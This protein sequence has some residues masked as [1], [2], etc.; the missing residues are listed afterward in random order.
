MGG[1]EEVQTTISPEVGR[2]IPEYSEYSRVF[3]V[4]TI[5]YLKCPIFNN[6]LTFKERG[7]CDSSTGK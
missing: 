2:S 6:D 7:K 1:Q 5:W 3:R 4:V